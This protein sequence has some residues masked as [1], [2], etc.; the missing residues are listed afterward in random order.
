[1]LRGPAPVPQEGKPKQL[2]PSR[3]SFL[4]T[5]PEGS[6]RGTYQVSIVDAFGKQLV[7]GKG[8]S[9][10]GKTLKISLDLSE[11][12]EQR[13]RLCVSR[14]REIPDCYQVTVISKK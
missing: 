1:V 12:P 6:L 13:Y 3:T 5:L 10:N 14:P 2:S 9:S 4:F 7:S 8:V 11:L